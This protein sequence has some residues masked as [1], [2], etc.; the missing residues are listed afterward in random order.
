MLG[1]NIGYEYRV[2]TGY[3]HRARTGRGAGA[4]GAPYV[5]GAASHLRRSPGTAVMPK[6]LQ[7]PQ[8]ET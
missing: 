6:R 7:F 4:G 8:L 1:A 2:R 5:R 3:E